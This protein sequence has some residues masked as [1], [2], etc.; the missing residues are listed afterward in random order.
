LQEEDKGKEP[1]HE[2][3]PAVSVYGAG[4][5]YAEKNQKKSIGGNNVRPE[6]KPAPLGK[7]TAYRYPVKRKQCGKII[8]IKIKKEGIQE[9]RAV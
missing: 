2:D 1:D 5:H 8:A 4:R 3:G 7:I 9:Y 6:K